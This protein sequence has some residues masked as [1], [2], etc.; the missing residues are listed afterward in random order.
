MPKMRLFVWFEVEPLSDYEPG[1]AFALA[2]NKEDAIDDAV[3]RKYKQEGDKNWVW[4]QYPCL[5]EE[6]RRVEP[7]V[8][9]ETEG[10]W[11]E[12]SD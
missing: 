4:R 10:F 5:A 8:V 12:G 7:L 6:L 3:L 1:I 9:G 11:M 2:P